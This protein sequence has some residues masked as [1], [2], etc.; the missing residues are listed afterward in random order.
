MKSRSGS[1]ETE[2]Y[3]FLIS[4]LSSPTSTVTSV[5]IGSVAEDG[6]VVTGPLPHRRRACDPRVRH[7]LGALEPAR[8]EA[9]RADEQFAAAVCELLE[10]ALQRRASLAGDSLGL[11]GLPEPHCVLR[12]EH[13]D[14]LALLESRAADEERDEDAFRILH[15]RGQVDQDLVSFCHR[16]SRLVARNLRRPLPSS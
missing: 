15:P 8:V 12:Q 2:A 10:E 4:D 3:V 7:E 11:A 16:S 14:L 5:A 1:C 6:C 13:R 9:D